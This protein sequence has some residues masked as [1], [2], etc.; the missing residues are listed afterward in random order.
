MKTLNRENRINNQNQCDYSMKNVYTNILSACSIFDTIMFLT[1]EEA[2]QS[3]PTYLSKYMCIT[4]V[5]NET[6]FHF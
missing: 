6:L 3:P 5:H 2:L 4:S 1:L